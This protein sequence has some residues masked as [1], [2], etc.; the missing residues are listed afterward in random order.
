MKIN[1]KIVFAL[2]G[3]TVILAFGLSSCN[4]N[5][6]PVPAKE[7]PMSKL[8]VPN[9][10]I[11]NTSKIE[12]ITVNMPS[13][14][15]FINNR[16]RV[17]F[18]TGSPS[19][20]GVFITAGSFDNQGMYDGKLR[21]PTSLDSVYIQTIAGNAKVALPGLGKKAGGVVVNFGENYGNNPP[22]TAVSTATKSAYAYSNNNLVF[23]SP[24]SS[25]VNIIQNGNFETDNFGQISKWYSSHPVDGKWYF[26]HYYSGNM[27]W[28]A[29]G[30]NHVIRTPYSNG[31]WYGG[32]S[33]MVNANPGDLITLSA[34]IK[35]V[36]NKSRLYSWL[37]LIPVDS[38]GNALEYFYVRYNYPSSQWKT[39]TIAATMPANTVKVN[40]LLWSWDLASNSSIYFD[41]VIVT[42]PVADSDGDGVNDE[43]D[44]YPNDATR[45]FNVYYPNKTDW[46]TLAFEDLWPGM[47]DYDFNDLVVDYHYKSVLNA[48]NKL[49]EFYMGYSVRAVGASLTNG[50]GLML[51]GDPTNVESVSGTRYT[52]NYIQNNAN[53]TEK[54]QTNTV[55][56]LF[57]DAFSMIGSSNSAFINT[58]E[59]VPY[60]LPDT[61]QLHVVY[62]NPVSKQVTGTAPYNPFMIINKDRGKEV[63]LAG[64]KPTDLANPAYFKTMSDDTDPATGK[65]YQTANNLPWALD[66]P[67]SFAY[68]VEQ[69][70]ILNAYNHFATWAE[71]AG[72]QY[73]DWYSDKAGYR[74][75]SNIYSPPAK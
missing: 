16:S 48:E 66:I 50:F 42:G 11:F 26:T 40:V 52:Q 30:G 13:S 49:V 28:Y 62:S 14:I 47:G 75:N 63:H 45:A 73:P 61:N 31:Y 53:G 24:K 6:L 35:S 36:G 15:N 17:N 51:G 37:Y 20:G 8:N 12:D 33:Q 27:E 60:V 38:H 43:L 1:N 22:D 25:V 9:G 19:D 71:S 29:D 58:K 46:G 3:L 70:A 10:F 41:N 54:G 34:D 18:Y 4:K 57:D 55:I 69:V 59:N 74:V 39:K 7:N 67:V 21:V 23:D 64:H 56:I 72:S 2:L 32:A 44:D 5:P 65:Y 68:P